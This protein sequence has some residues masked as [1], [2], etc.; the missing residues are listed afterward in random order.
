MVTI[1]QVK[2]LTLKSSG[3]FI[4]ISL[5]CSDPLV[6]GDFPSSPSALK[7]AI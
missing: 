7:L 6:K 4:K 1:G 3:S 2:K 5:A